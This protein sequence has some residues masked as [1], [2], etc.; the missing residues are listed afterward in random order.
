MLLYDDNTG[1]AVFNTWQQEYRY[2]ILQ[3]WQ[4]AGGKLV[5]YVLFGVCIVCKKTIPSLHINA[6]ASLTS[7]ISGGETR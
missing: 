4:V 7:S 6:N 3:Y 5:K 2:F 1:K